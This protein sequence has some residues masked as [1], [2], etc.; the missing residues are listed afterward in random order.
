VSD[1]TNFLIEIFEG[2]F[3]SK[4]RIEVGNGF[5]LDE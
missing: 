3:A 5:W 4:G 1:E 2:E